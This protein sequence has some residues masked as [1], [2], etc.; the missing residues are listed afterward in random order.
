MYEDIVLYSLLGIICVSAIIFL[1]K[2]SDLVWEH[3]RRNY[4]GVDYSH[5]HGNTQNQK[6]FKHKNTNKEVKNGKNKEKIC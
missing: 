6:V 4:L 3:C 5:F 2:Y 1:I